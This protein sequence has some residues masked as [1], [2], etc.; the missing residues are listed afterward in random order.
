MALIGKNSKLQPAVST[1]EKYYQKVKYFRKPAGGASTDF[2]TSFANPAQ[3]TVTG[4]AIIP[5]PVIYYMTSEL[6]DL[7]ITEDSNNI[8]LE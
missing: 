8:I 2:A 7:M 4:G 6:G 3:G 1:P 5:D